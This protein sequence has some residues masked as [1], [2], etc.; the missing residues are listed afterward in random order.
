[1]YHNTKA[2]HTAKGELQIRAFAIGNILIFCVA[3]A[4]LGFE[5][6]LLGCFVG[7]DHALCNEKGI[8]NRYKK[9]ILNTSKELKIALKTYCYDHENDAKFREIL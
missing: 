4:C 5:N 7:S 8:I 6:F 1:M 9:N 2:A 3:R